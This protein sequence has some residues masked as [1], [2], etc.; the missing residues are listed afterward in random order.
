MLSLNTCPLYCSF[1]VARS[2]YFSKVS[3]TK[4]PRAA[5]IM[6]VFRMYLSPGAWH[7]EYHSVS[8][9]YIVLFFITKSLNDIEVLKL[10]DRDKLCNGNAKVLCKLRPAAS[11]FAQIQCCHMSLCYTA[12]V[13]QIYVMRWKEWSQFSL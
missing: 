7:K 12:Q 13:Q 1:S 4:N 9:C 10:T 8:K 11:P 2:D 6:Y 5:F 3:V